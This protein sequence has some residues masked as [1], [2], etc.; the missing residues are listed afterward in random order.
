MKCLSVWVCFTLLLCALG[1]WTKAADLPTVKGKIAVIAHRGG[2]SLAPEN[3]LAA[4]KKA[5]VLG[6]D[7]VEIDVR[8]TKDRSLIC[9]HDS[10][11]DRTTDGKGKIEDLTLEEVKSLDAGSWFSKDCQGE[12]VPT[13]KEV[14][15]LCKDKIHV[16]LDHK[17]GNTEE[18]WKTIREAGMTGSVVVYNRVAELKEWKRIAPEV[19]VMPSLPDPFQR[20]GGVAAFLKVL[21]AE[22]LDGGLGDWTLERVDEAHREGVQV[23][24]DCLG[25]HDNAPW[26]R[27]ALE[28]GVDGIQTDRPDLLIEALRKRE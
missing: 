27:R 8:Q 16:Y 6:A 15:S 25:L 9:I 12:R 10:T 7:Y 13:L 14:L 1:G 19:P 20:E 17:E 28:M 24:V 2:S 26:H 22:V 4:F 23:Y 11:V 3:T 18:I 21:P 5:I